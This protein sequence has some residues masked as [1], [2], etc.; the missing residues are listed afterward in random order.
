MTSGDF[1]WTADPSHKLTVALETLLNP[2]TAGGDEAGPMAHFDAAQSY[3]W[4]AVTWAGAYTG[5]AD[6]AALDAA[7]TFDAAG[8]LNPVGG[9]FGWALDA[10]S[11]TLSLTYTPVPEPGTL[12]LVGTA[13]V[14]IAW[15]RRRQ[16]RIADQRPWSTDSDS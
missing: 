13:A 14:A 16:P 10:T 3:S 9:T 11:R 2:T 12:A 5:P 15:A 4:P 1:L 6:A 8:F 7:T